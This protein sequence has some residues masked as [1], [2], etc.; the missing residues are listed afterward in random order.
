LVDVSNTVNLFKISFYAISVIGFLL[1]AIKD[2]ILENVDELVSHSFIRA[3][4]YKRRKKLKTALQTSTLNGIQLTEEDKEKI[5]YQV[6]A[7]EKIEAEGL[8]EE[9]LIKIRRRNRLLIWMIIYWIIGEHFDIVFLHLSLTLIFYPENL[10]K[11]Y[12]FCYLYD[13]IKKI[14]HLFLRL[15]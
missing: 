8:K 14:L 10:K 4:R 5:K 1:I 6:L 9:S 12:F 15:Y 13:L 3:K 11:K 2:V 7:D